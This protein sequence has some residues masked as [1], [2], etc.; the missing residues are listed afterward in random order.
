METINKK[1]DR[2]HFSFSTDFE[3]DSI[4]Y[5]HSRTPE[6]RFEALELLRRIVYGE[7]AATGRLQRVLSF[8]EREQS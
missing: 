2:T 3:D 8:D 1:V 7:D 5:W 4:E 6:E